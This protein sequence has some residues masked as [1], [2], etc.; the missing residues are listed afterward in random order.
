M[1]VCVPGSDQWPYSRSAFA[2]LLLRYKLIKDRDPRRLERC[3]Q[4]Y[5]YR[6]LALHPS[7]PPPLNR[8]NAMAEGS[9]M[10]GRRTARTAARVTGR[11]TVVSGAL[12]RRSRRA[13][14][15]SAE[16]VKEK[17]SMFGKR[18]T[19]ELNGRDQLAGALLSLG[20]LNWGLIGLANFD[21]VRAVFGKSAASRVAY[22]LVGASGA[23]AIARGVRL[24]RR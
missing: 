12:L 2:S 10:G 11:A 17:M 7:G 4:R 19:D 8:P 18:L 9:R 16:S 5:E 6:S 15:G 13:L 20:A 23:Y 22:G 3:G 24:A 21:A 14:A 1:L